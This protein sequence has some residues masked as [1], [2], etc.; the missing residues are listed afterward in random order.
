MPVN[1]RPTD[2]GGKQYPELCIE[3][4]HFVRLGDFDGQLGLAHSTEH[5]SRLVTKSGHQLTTAV[6][7]QVCKHSAPLGGADQGGGDASPCRLVR[8]AARTKLS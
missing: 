8:C 1:N 7:A 4:T 2:L 3:F 5:L 6:G